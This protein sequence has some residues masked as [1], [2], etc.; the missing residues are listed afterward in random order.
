MSQIRF[1]YGCQ[2]ISRADIQEVVAALG[3]ELLTGG[4]LLVDFERAL[5]NRFGA[6]H[7]VA[8]SSGTAALHL[9]SLTLG[10]TQ[11]DAVI[12][13]AITFLAT[14]NCIRYVGAEVIFADVDHETGLMTA[15]SLAEAIDKARALQFV[16]RA[17]IPVHYAGQVACIGDVAKAHNLVV[18]EDAAHAIGSTYQSYN[19]YRP[20]GDCYSSAMTVF[21]F[22]PVKTITT[23]EGGAV[24]TND[25]GLAVRLKNLRNH[26]MNRDPQKFQNLEQAFSSDGHANSWYYEMP[27]LGFNYRL[28]DIQAA[29]GISQLRR[30]NQFLSRRSHI[31]R[32]YDDLFNDLIPIAT[33]LRK[34][35]N[36]EP[37]WHL[38]VLLVEFEKTN[39]S[40]VTLM[41]R[42]AEQGIGTQVHYLPVYRQPY[43]ERR[44]G[45]IRLTGAEAFYRRA[46]SLPLFPALDDDD[47]REIAK[48]VMF[49]LRK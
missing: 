46:I 48:S 36:C 34:L 39:T 31:V 8:C 28:S 35:P 16:P 9:A 44:Y 22:H 41:R 7:A 15:D 45:A 3:G 40:R 33:P 5:A 27:E 4:R 37:G 30:L 1:P 14:A 20:V 26:G 17:V 23:G 6:K 38:Y 32:L 25:E 12:V 19:S 2:N 43:Y 24:L 11:S 49:A 18:V 47:A 13:P 21:S 29:L 10:L 42:L